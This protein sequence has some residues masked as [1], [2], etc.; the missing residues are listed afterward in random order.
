MIF[1]YL[2]RIGFLEIDSTHSKNYNLAGF[3]RRKNC[4]ILLD[5]L[6]WHQKNCRKCSP[7][8]AD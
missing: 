2:T 8:V 5:E 6:K 7:S 4:L 3:Q 1:R